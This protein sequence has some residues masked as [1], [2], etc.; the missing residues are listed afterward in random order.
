[1]NRFI[2]II[3]GLLAMSIL[4]GCEQSQTNSPDSETSLTSE[5]NSDNV[6]STT[7]LSS[8]STSESASSSTETAVSKDDTSKTT[9][10]E[11]TDETDND[12]EPA[13]EMKLSPELD[14]ITDLFGEFGAFYYEY[15]G[16]DGAYDRIT[17]GEG[18]DSFENEN[19]LHF[20]KIVNAEIKTYNALTEKLKSM[21]TEK[22]IENSSEYILDRFDTKENDDL[23][24]QNKGAGGYL[25]Y[26]YLRINSIDYP[27]ED[28]VALDMSVVGEKENWG[29][30]KDQEE[31]FTMTLKK[32]D[33]GLRIDEITRD[34][35]DF[36]ALDTVVYNNVYMVFDN[37]PEFAEKIREES[38]WQ[39]TPNETEKILKVLKDYSDFYLAMTPSD[40]EKFID[41]S[42]NISIDGT[43]SFGD[44]YTAEY[45]KT[46][47]LP[48]NTLGELNEK[49][50]GF[51][52][53]KAKDDFLNMTND[54]FFTLSE[55]GDLYMSNNPYGRSLGLG[56]DKLY[57]D[58]IEYPDDNTI[59][60]TVTSFGDKKNWDTDEDIKDTATAKLVRTDNG[61]RIGECD[62]NMIDYFGYYDEISFDKIPQ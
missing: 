32:T 41:R 55:N 25:G 30:E 36:A 40:N 52:T 5:N 35:I 58:S 12:P 14:G 6:S 48:A 1:M 33:G 20:G 49:L 50:D 56:M 46:V 24:V 21:L 59:I 4:T 54:K 7:S 38:G 2:K 13:I 43:N 34:P 11:N 57:L 37:V 10:S 26:D 19:G 62:S 42:R 47:G 29:Y 61:L 51:V 15:L 27:D 22:C 8:E 44:P 53:E 31:D 39:K 45:Y 18:A 60:I 28:T 17:S 9:P 3:A 23:Y 16:S